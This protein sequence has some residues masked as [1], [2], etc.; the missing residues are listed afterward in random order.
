MPTNIELFEQI[1]AAITDKTS[2]GSISPIDIGDNMRD[3][4]S[5]VDQETAGI[6]PY[7][8]FIGLLTQSGTS[9]PTVTVKFNNTGVTPSIGY[10]G[11]GTSGFIFVGLGL[12]E[13]NC[14]VITSNKTTSAKN[15]HCNYYFNATPILLLRTYNLVNS[16]YEN[17]MLSNTPIEIRFYP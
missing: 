9:A 1:D 12:T 16:A 8:T 13:A 2:P 4:V 17:D 3:I 14:Q 11:V 5:Y 6:P 7:K 10:V 15:L